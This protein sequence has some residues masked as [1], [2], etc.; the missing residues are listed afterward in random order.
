MK[1]Q[2][3]D[4]LMA[5]RDRLMTA[6]YPLGQKLRPSEVAGDF[7]VSAGT[8]REIMLRLSVDGLLIYTDQ[9][10]FRVTESSDQ[11]LHEITEFRIMLEQTG[12][13]RSIERGGIEWESQM[14]A[15]HHKLSHIEARIRRTGDVESVLNHWNHAELEFHLSLMGAADLPILLDTFR[16]V[17]A[18]FRQQIVTPEK[19]YAHRSG[20]ITE[21]HRIL[22]AA[23]DRDAAASREAIVQHLR[24]NLLPGSVSAA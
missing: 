7:G 14:A 11:R 23:L 3:P 6:Y 5:M 2:T 1:Q 15:A 17:Y 4:I 16:S 12:L 19:R 20:N 13:T 10:G 22:E 9:R 21:H 18:Q 8:L 24:G